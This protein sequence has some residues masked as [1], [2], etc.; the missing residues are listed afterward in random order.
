MW[1]TT[2]AGTTLRTAIPAGM[3]AEVTAAAAATTEAYSRRRSFSVSTLAHHWALK[4]SL[5]F[6]GS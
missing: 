6:T 1:R 2:T 5:I 3:A 4:S